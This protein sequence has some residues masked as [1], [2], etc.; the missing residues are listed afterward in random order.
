MTGYRAL[1]GTV[2]AWSILI[3]LVAVPV[4][5]IITPAIGEF[6]HLQVSIETKKQLVARLR[7]ANQGHVQSQQQ[8][9]NIDTGFRNADMLL[10]ATEANYADT[11]IRDYF[12][13]TVEQSGGRLQS[14]Q[15]LIARPDGIL[16]GH[17]LRASFTATLPQLL[18]IL[19]GLE[20]QRPLLFIE[21]LQIQGKNN[22]PE[23]ETGGQPLRVQINVIGYSMPEVAF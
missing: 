7:N 17:T 8:A 12:I 3:I 11:E 20:T 1:I 5:Q 10:K 2:A 22:R 19:Y 15:N 23:D 18:D 16:Q 14:S 4:T 9:G 21:D 6:H 13:K